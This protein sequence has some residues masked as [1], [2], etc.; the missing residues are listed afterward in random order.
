LTELL[1]QPQFAPYAI[2][3]MYSVL[4]AATNGAFDIVPVEKID[5]AREA[6][7]RE[8]KAKHGKLVET[9]NTGAKPEDKDNEAVLKVA[10]EIA[11]QYEVKAAK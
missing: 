11:K 8:L 7:L 6:L 10:K 2:W 3:E 5:A 4:Y 1:K 9:L